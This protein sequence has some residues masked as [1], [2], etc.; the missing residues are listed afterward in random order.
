M[1]SPQPGDVT[2]DVADEEKQEARAYLRERF[3]RAI[4]GLVGRSCKVN[5]FE[6][7]TVTAEFRGSDIDVM[8]FFVAKL[9]TPMGVFPEALLRTNDIINVHFPDVGPS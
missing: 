5:M 4:T 1:E 6:N 8:H 3:L 2:S 9:A 7:T